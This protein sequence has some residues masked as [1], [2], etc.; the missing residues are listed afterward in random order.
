MSWASTHG[1]STINFHFSSYWV[2]AWCTGRLLCAKIEIGGA[3][4][5][6]WHLHARYVCTRMRIC[7]L[8]IEHV[9]LFRQVQLLAILGPM[10][11]WAWKLDEATCQNQRKDRDG[12]HHHRLYK[13]SRW[14]CRRCDLG[15]RYLGACP[16]MGAFHFNSQNSYMGA[17][18]GVGA[19]SGQYGMYIHHTFI[20]G[21]LLFSSFIWFDQLKETCLV[22]MIFSV[23]LHVVLQFIQLKW[24]RL[25][26]FNLCTI[27]GKGHRCH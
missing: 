2:L 14:L 23:D 8:Y 24:C 27:S 9:W 13:C 11:S 22:K 20:I 3:N 5:W 17:Y 4:L 25:K 15:S 7:R 26:V 16:K 19:C 10:Y 1:R 12:L 18:P 21:C 6:A